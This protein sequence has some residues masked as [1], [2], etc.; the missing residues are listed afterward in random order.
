MIALAPRHD[1]RR[2]ALQVHNYPALDGICSLPSHTTFAD[3]YF[4]TAEVCD[5]YYSHYADR[6]TPE[7]SPLHAPEPSEVPA[8]VYISGW[9]PL[10]DEARAYVER[11][12]AAKTPVFV[13]EL[14]DL[15]HGFVLMT[16]ACRRAREKR[17][18]RADCGDSRE[19]RE[20]GARGHFARVRPV[21][22]P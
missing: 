14:T 4:L 12:R 10:R 21:H 18:K 22:R 13:E 5:W 8:I 15:R 20:P 7:L 6:K 16:G 1:A 2:P 17:R 11:L 3:G 19:G 9:D